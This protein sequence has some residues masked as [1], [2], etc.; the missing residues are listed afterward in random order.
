MPCP[1]DKVQANVLGNAVTQGLRLG[2]KDRPHRENRSIIPGNRIY[3][4]QTEA[5]YF[6][7]VPKG[8]PMIWKRVLAVLLV[9]APPG[10]PTATARDGKVP[11]SPEGRRLRGL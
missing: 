11:L 7:P 10:L 4:W 1:L 2:R 3:H 5:S 6:G 9:F 8:T